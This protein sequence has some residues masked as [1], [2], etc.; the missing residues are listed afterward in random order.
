MVVVASAAPAGCRSDGAGWHRVAFPSAPG[1]AVAAL[2]ADTAVGGHAWWS[3]DAAGRWRRGGFAYEPFS[4]DGRRA[5][6][7]S[8]ARRGRT[9]SA[10]GFALSGVHGSQRPVLWL[11]DGGVLRETYLLRELFGGPSTVGIGR[12]A[13]GPR[14]FLVTGTRTTPSGRMAAA[15]W[16]ADAPPDWTRL[17]GRPALAGGG[18]AEQLWGA[19]VA[20]GAARSAVVGRAERF[21]N[22]GRNPSDAAVWVSED[23]R[24]WRRLDLPEERGRQ[25]LHRVVVGADGGFVAVG[26]DDGRAALWTSGDGLAW[27]RRLLA[28]PADV[29]TAVDAAGSYAAVLADGRVRL[30]RD[31]RAVR[32]P[33]TGRATGVALA[34]DPAGRVLLA[35]TTPAGVQLWRT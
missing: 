34:V 29:N 16:R 5:R 7:V 15:V 26:S 22:G 9:V 24:S 23:D 35:V 14:G 12:M 28:A 1:D 27:R 17:D 32:A 13:A 8:A 3:L 21:F 2:S 6:L 33:H 25:E 19:D 11:A 20:A 31:G 4:E 10:V 30:Y 18:P